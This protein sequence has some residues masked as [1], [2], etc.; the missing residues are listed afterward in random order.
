MPKKRRLVEDERAWPPVNPDDLPQVD[1]A[2]DKLMQTRKRSRVPSPKVIPLADPPKVNWDAEVS[3]YHFC[4]KPQKREL[5]GLCVSD[6]MLSEITSYFEPKLLNGTTIKLSEQ[7]FLDLMQEFGTTLHSR[8]KPD[9]LHA[10]FNIVFYHRLSEH[11]QYF[12]CTL[13]QGD[14]WRGYCFLPIKD[15]CY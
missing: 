14:L 11:H 8:Q 3:I 10:S 1:E 12:L 9:N 6:V 7:E 2:L 15:G 13:F 5:K 4:T